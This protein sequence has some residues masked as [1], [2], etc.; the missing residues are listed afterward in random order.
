MNKY[1]KKINSILLI[2]SL[3]FAFFI[4][5][6]ALAQENNEDLDFKLHFTYKK[7]AEKQDDIQKNCSFSSQAQK[8]HIMKEIC[9]YDIET[10]NQSKLLQNHCNFSDDTIKGKAIEYYCAFKSPL[11]RENILAEFCS[12]GT[13]SQKKQHISNLEGIIRIGPALKR[14]INFAIQ[15]ELN[16]K[17]Q[18]ALDLSIYNVTENPHSEAAYK[19]GVIHGFSPC[20]F[21]N[22]QQSLQY[23]QKAYEKPESFFMIAE[24]FRLSGKQE[25]AQKIYDFYKQAIDAGVKEAYYNISLYM[26]Q[27]LTK[28]DNFGQTPTDF[29]YKTVVDYLTQA[30]KVGDA[31]AQNDL[32]IITKYIYKSDNQNA[33]KAIAETYISQSAKQNF[34]PALYNQ[35]IL[36]LSENCS[37]KSKRLFE[38]NIS[39]LLKQDYEPVYNLLIR[40][41]SNE[42]YAPQVKNFIERLDIDR[43]YKKHAVIDTLNIN[44]SMIRLAE[45]AF[46]V[47]ERSFEYDNVTH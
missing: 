36:Y 26:F 21:K 25:Y 12:L 23:F 41:K 19:L 39:K 30:A 40:L 16:A 13:N 20:G 33:F 34:A 27:I 47:Y 44:K 17:H 3:V 11:S 45:S 6:L 15:K 22:M 42:C 46:N 1:I 10:R 9:A 28:E 38:K 2:L 35:I 14:T 7:L 31:A 43:T 5:N 18:E 29:Q 32:P 37:D 4:S 24:L 8:K